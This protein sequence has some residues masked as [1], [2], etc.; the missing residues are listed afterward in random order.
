MSGD[1]N[2]GRWIDI[3]D[4]TTLRPAELQEAEVDDVVVVFFAAI[5]EGVV[6]YQGLC[7]HE[8]YPLVDGFLDRGRLVCA[9]H[10]STFD[11]R[12]GEVRLGPADKPLARYEV[13]V[14]GGRIRLFVPDGGLPV[15]K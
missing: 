10:G 5:D 13:E 9:L 6:A 7:S 11:A 12:T 8:S 4:A 14:V 15:N 1:V 3:G 2:D